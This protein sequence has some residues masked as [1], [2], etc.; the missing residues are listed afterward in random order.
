MPGR[1]AAPPGPASPPGIAS[2]SARS[3]PPAPPTAPVPRGRRSAAVALVAG[4]CLATLLAGCGTDPVADSPAEED[5]LLEPVAAPGPDPYTASTVRALSAPAPRPPA[6]DAGTRGAPLRAQTLR[7][8]SGGTPGLYGGVEAVGNCDAGRQLDL[9]RE[10]RDKA[11]AFA[12]GAGVSPAGLSGFLRG[13]TPVV[14]RTDTRVTAHGFRDGS[15]VSRQSVLQAGTAVL[16]D[17]RGTPRV[18]CAGGNPLNPPVA[19]DGPVVHRGR[20]WAGYA[21]E[22][23]VVIEPAER[24]ADRLVIVDVLDSSWID[25]ETG[26]DGERDSRPEV[27]P[28]EARDDLYSYPPAA[29]RSRTPAPAASSGP[30]TAAT[31]P[32]VPPA[33][34]GVP[35]E[36]P[37]PPA[38]PG[39]GSDPG[40]GTDPVPDD[41]QPGDDLTSPGEDD[42]ESDPELLLPAGAPED[43][44]GVF[45]G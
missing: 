12:R 9:V 25:R 22:R 43:D 3:G 24:V 1:R 28:P 35:A 16:V 44:P 31:A 32:A 10:S 19:A 34:P 27:I 33:D 11:R 4:V 8:L 23:I 5:I 14:L 26:T 36:P 42:P 40:S 21:P 38:D 2:P 20:P 6:P 39:D 7:T 13:L 17:R 15:D 30:S 18:R 41:L 37:L 45:A 29:S